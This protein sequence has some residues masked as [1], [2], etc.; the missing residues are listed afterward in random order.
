MSIVVIGLNHRTSPLEV[1]ERVGVGRRH[2]GREGRG[3]GER[4]EE[5][6]QTGAHAITARAGASVGRRGAR[7]RCRKGPM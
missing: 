5:S 3:K 2:A 6:E 4:R 1:L 7:R